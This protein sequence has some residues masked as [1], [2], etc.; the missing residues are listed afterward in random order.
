MSHVNY[1]TF[2]ILVASFLLVTLIG[3]ASARWRPA[4]DPMQLSEW[5]LGG[6]GFGTFV[7]WFLI[8]G[9]IY[10]AYTFIAVPA[11]IYGVGALGFFVVG[12]GAL[13]F[14]IA[15]VIMARFWSIARRRGYL[16]AADFVRDRFGD[17]QLEVAIA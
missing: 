17:R 11:L 3:F 2:T 9:D 8:G 7:S 12:Y 15:F 10:T 13:A 6:R 5:G 4:E 16:T 14:P 1:V